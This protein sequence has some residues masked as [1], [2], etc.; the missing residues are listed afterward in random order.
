MQ[1]SKSKNEL[2]LEALNNYYQLQDN[3]NKKY[4]AKKSKILLDDQLTLREKKKEVEKLKRNCI[5]CNQ[6]GGTI[7]KYENGNLIALCGN[8]TTPCKLNISIEKNKVVNI[9]SLIIDLEN[10][11]EKVKV[12]IIKVK[13][14]FLFNY[15]NQEKS[16]QLFNKYRENL[17]N[18]NTNY[19]NL[20]IKFNEIINNDERNLKIKENFLLKHELIDRV[21]ILNN[22]FNSTNNPGYIKDIVELYINELNKITI[23]LM[24]YKY[25]L[26]LV[27][28]IDNKKK[29]F[30]L[31]QEKFIENSFE[32]IIK[33]HKINS[34]K[35]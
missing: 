20:F 35:K 22:E 16:L 17:E 13:L 8:T 25:E 10:E 27:Q 28:E 32:I 26:N 19:N 6:I 31:T 9:K 21:E 34:F 3:Y 33:E 11:I 4:N 5:N 15:N 12:D 24:D 23:K 29:I 18:L 14:N 7:F 2:Y 30:E 1:S